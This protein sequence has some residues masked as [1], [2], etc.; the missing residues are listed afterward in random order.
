MS[1][2][3]ILCEQSGVVALAKPAGLPTQAPPGI[4][5]AEAWLRAR[6]PRGAYLGIPH[7]L[8][9]AVSGVLLMAVTPRAARLLSRQFGRRLV[10]KHYVAVVAVGPGAEASLPRDGEKRSWCDAIAKVH[11]EAR[12]MI[13]AADDPAGRAAET[14]VSCLGRL[15]PSRPGG[16][17]GAAVLAL[18]PR[19]GRMHQLRVQSASRGLPILGDDLYGGGAFGA[20][21]CDP[22]QRPVALHARG[23]RCLD[24]DLGGALEIVA[25][26]P[27]FWPAE[28]VRLA[29]G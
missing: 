28:V 1:D 2:P 27:A 10:E 21:E 16:E 22:R 26:F 3:T 25:P 11:D 23:I 9:R 29:G 6:L 5:S 15:P 12:A 20:P 24:P 14:V 18:R 8:D 19:T 4:A 13:V 17:P 7:R